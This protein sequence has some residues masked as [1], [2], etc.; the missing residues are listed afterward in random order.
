LRLFLFAFGD[1]L[2]SRAR[3]FIDKKFTFL[4]EKPHFA[5]SFSACDSTL[6]LACQARLAARFQGV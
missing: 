6:S 5:L 2:W 4:E 3:W 1:A